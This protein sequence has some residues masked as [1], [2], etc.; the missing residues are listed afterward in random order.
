MRHQLGI[1]ALAM[2]ALGHVSSVVDQTD[3]IKAGE[4]LNLQKGHGFS[5]MNADQVDLC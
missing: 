1:F 3:E 4:N 2:F 5:R